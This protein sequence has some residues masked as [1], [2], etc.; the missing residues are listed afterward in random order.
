MLRRPV[1]STPFIAADFSEATPS[2]GFARAMDCN[3]SSRDNVF[4]ERLWRSVKYEEV[5]LK[6]YDSVGHAR[7]SIAAYLTWYKQSRSAS[8]LQCRSP[9]EAY[10]ATLPAIPSA[11]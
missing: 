9:D 3:G 11:A 8:S 10:I 5:Y 2:R 4:V 7:R 6:A 1:E